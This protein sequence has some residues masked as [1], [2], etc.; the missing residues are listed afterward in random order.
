MMEANC[1][2]YSSTKAESLR[3][4]CGSLLPAVKTSIQSSGN[5][6]ER[7]VWVAVRAR[8][9]VARERVDGAKVGVSTAAALLMEHVAA[10]RHAADM[11]HGQPTVCPGTLQLTTDSQHSPA[12]G[13]GLSFGPKAGSGCC[14]AVLVLS[15]AC[16]PALRCWS[17]M[18]TLRNVH[19][20]LCA[21]HHAL[22]PAGMHICQ[23]GHRQC[24]PGLL[25]AVHL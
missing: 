18:H 5:T 12:P 24:A 19:Q 2:A 6:A 22:V 10:C 23:P 25:A 3:S 20:H 9:L 21:T 11:L 8:P 15:T 16:T 14:M 7:S 4:E 1:W 17:C 13:E